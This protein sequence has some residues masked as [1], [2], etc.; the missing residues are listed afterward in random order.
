MDPR[1]PGHRFT[2]RT[3]LWTESRMC[4]AKRSFA[5]SKIT[6]HGNDTPGPFCTGCDQHIIETL[7]GVG[8]I[9]GNYLLVF[10]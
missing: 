8:S 3:I 1:D 6:G 2:G 7:P 10:R 4:G 9:G 5:G